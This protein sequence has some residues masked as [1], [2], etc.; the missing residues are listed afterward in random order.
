MSEIMKAFVS[1]IMDEAI[2]VMIPKLADAFRQELPTLNDCPEKGNADWCDGYNQA[3][4]DAEDALKD[5]ERRLLRKL[6]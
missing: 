5:Y 6:P 1:K 2:R 3:L 4:S